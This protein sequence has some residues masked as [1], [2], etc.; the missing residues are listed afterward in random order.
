MQRC[1]SLALALLAATHGISRSQTLVDGSSYPGLFSPAA[2][3]TAETDTEPGLLNVV[4]DP[5]ATTTGPLGTH[6]TATATGGADLY[7]LGQVLSSTG[8]Q[9]ALSN[10]SLQF[11]VSNDPQSL[12]GSLDTGLN[13]ELAWSATATLNDPVVSLAPNRV[14]R[15][16]F[17]VIAG[18]GLLNSTLGI[19]PAFG[20]ELI[21]G[22]GTPLGFSGGGTSANVLGLDLLEIVGAP[23]GT[24]RVT[25]EFRT[26]ET[27]PSG[28]ASIRFTGSAALPA[29]VLD[30]GA[31]FA[32][33]SN[34]MLVAVDSYTLWIEDS[35]V[36]DPSDWDRNAD[37][38]EDG[39]TNLEEY[40]LNTDP[41]SGAHGEAFV[42]VGDADGPDGESSNLV[43]T[44]A[45]VEGAEFS[46]GTGGNSGDLIATTASVGYRVEGSFDLETWDVAVE[47][48]VANDSFMAGLPP[49]GTGWTYRSFRVPGETAETEKAFLR[50]VFE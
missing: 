25:A 43:M 8:A 16:S 10:Q 27:V 22:A 21:D 26:G 12:L 7:L 4:L 20:V 30:I 36:E 2:S 18:S 28:A 14:Y 34:L 49:L 19:N 40:A 37:P 31:N 23:A 9:V 11:N 50:V 32:S 44:V 3:V 15:V 13:V 1:L 33:V 46:G 47:E 39:R 17:E 45:V 38:D 24:S 6:W 29:T 35:G 41:A 5:A 48:V 42:A